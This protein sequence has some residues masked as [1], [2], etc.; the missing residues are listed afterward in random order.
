MGSP[1][2]QAFPLMYGKDRVYRRGELLLVYS[3]FDNPKWEVREYS[4]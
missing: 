1:D 3:M 2:N 4:D